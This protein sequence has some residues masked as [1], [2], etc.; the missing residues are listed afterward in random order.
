MDISTPETIQS[1]AFCGGFNFKSNMINTVIDMIFILKKS[2]QY[3]IYYFSESY[4]QR[5]SY[6]F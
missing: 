4:G 2:Y 5:V 1:Q 6:C 3:L